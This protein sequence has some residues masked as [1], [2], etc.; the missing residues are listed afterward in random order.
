MKCGTRI[1][2]QGWDIDHK[3]TWEPARIARRPKGA[4]NYPAG[5]HCVR[6]EVDGARLAVHESRFRV[7]DNR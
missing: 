3:E 7:I 2:V 6:F 1:E 5:Y 4:G